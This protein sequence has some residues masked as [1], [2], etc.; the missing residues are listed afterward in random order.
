MH[1]P[2]P[3][4]NRA[5]TGISDTPALH[6]EIGGLRTRLEAAT[7]QLA[8]E[9]ALA[10][11]ILS[12]RSLIISESPALTLVFGAD[13][14][15]QAKETP[16]MSQILSSAF[17][18]E[19]PDYELADGFA[20][21]VAKSLITSH[22]PDAGGDTE[23]SQNIAKSL[24]GLKKD[25]A[26]S[27]A[28]AILAAPQQ[29][30]SDPKAQRV[31]RYRLHL[32]LAGAVPQFTSEEEARSNAETET[33]GAAWRVRTQAAFKSLHLITGDG[34]AWNQ[35][36]Q[37]IVRTR[38]M[39]LIHMVNR[40]QPAILSLHERLIKGDPVA[41][42]ALDT[43]AIDAIFQRIWSVLGTKDRTIPY[44]PPYQ[45]WLDILLPALQ[46]LDPGQKPGQ[47][48][49]HFEPPIEIR[50]APTINSYGQYYNPT[51]PYQSYGEERPKKYYS[52]W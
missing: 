22:H 27:I 35:F 42:E 45:N 34:D 41:A 13:D 6:G 4:F 3:E 10:R 5:F 8:L 24:R 40:V 32:A 19:V 16:G 1:Q 37:S 52:E 26:F 39:E 33:H 9:R 44:N 21:T 17:A 31:E 7:T 25:A 18:R 50:S 48:Y 23:V 38:H 49:T 51:N 15:T 12:A 36:L 11:D 14:I 47:T 2:L 29:T 20:A 46:L 43:P 30:E 28:S